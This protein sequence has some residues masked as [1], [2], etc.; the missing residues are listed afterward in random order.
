MFQDDWKDLALIHRRFWGTNCEL[1]VSLSRRN[2][3]QFSF[4]S[5]HTE[6]IKERCLLSE[7]VLCLQRGDWET[8]SLNKRVAWLKLAATQL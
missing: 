6:R 5:L 2:I 4:F 1:G 3:S 8:V 7:S